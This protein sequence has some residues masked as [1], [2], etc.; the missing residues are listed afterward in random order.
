M[1]DA[2]LYIAYALIA[3]AALASFVFPLLY[4][5]RNIADAKKSLLAVGVLFVVL[6]VTYVLSSGEFY[7][8]GIEKFDMTESGIKLVSAGLNSFY[9]LLVIS[10]VAVVYSEVSSVFK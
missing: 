7:F 3:I 5:A 9:V 6:L 2:G 4:V 10:I 8:S 1:V